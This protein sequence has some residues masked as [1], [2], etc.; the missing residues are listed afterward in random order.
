MLRTSRQAHSVATCLRT[1][2]RAPPRL[3]RAVASSNTA[4]SPEDGEEN[5]SLGHFEWSSIMS[6]A[7]SSE[8]AAQVSAVVEAWAHKEAQFDFNA[9]DIPEI[10]WSHWE[11]TIKAPGVVA[12]FKAA[13]E[14]MDFSNKG[15]FE[16][17][18][19]S[20]SYK[21]ALAK[22]G[23][24]LGGFQTH[25]LVETATAREE[26]LAAEQGEFAKSFVNHLTEDLEQ[27]SAEEKTLFLRTL[28]MDLA[29]F[30][31]IAE[32]VEDEHAG[33]GIDATAP[34]SD[35]GA[36]KE[37]IEEFAKQSVLNVN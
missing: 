18:Q 26:K 7:Y 29:E 11:E 24:D 15:R 16:F 37:D 36:S 8:Q 4:A 22:A 13:Y 1:I 17:E 2:V 9:T 14:A 30:P 33:G 20:D 12:Q 10:D 31:E 5:S 6:P 19:F 25:S 28:E 3:Q 34:M 27:I 32:A 35:P 23:V 21:A